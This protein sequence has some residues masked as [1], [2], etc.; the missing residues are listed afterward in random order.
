MSEIL[1]PECGSDRIYYD[2]TCHTYPGGTREDGTRIYMACLPC[3]SA[4]EYCCY[5]CTWSWNAHL[6]R[7]NPRT[8]KN[9][10]KKPSWYVQPVEKENSWF[11]AVMPGIVSIY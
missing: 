11:L 9:D 6:N 1:C 5:D 2:Y 7:G 8:E 4:I 3:D 10:A